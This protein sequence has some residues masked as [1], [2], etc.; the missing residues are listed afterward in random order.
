MEGRQF[1]RIGRVS[2]KVNMELVRK[3]DLR[4]KQVFAMFNTEASNMQAA[5]SD[6]DNISL[7]KVG[8]YAHIAIRR[9]V[10]VDVK[11]PGYCVAW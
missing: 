11:T 9:F 5:R 4:Y 8:H 1:F 7:V 2:F 3:L 6:D 10:V